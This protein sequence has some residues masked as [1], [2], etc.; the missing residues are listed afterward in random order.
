MYEGVTV[1]KNKNEIVPDDVLSKCLEKNKSFFGLARAAEG[2]LIIVRQKFSPES[3]PLTVE[4]LNKIQN[5]PEYKS[6][7]LV[8]FFGNA[9]LVGEPDMQP[10]VLLEDSDNDPILAMFMDGNFEEFKK[11]GSARPPEVFAFEEYFKPK[12]KKLGLYHDF[13]LNKIMDEIKSSDTSRDYVKTMCGNRG[14][15][16]FLSGNGRV[17]SLSVKGDVSSKKTSWGWISDTYPAAVAETI[18]EKKEEPKNAA[19]SLLAGLSGKPKSGLP[20]FKKKETAESSSVPAPDVKPNGGDQQVSTPVPAATPSDWPTPSDDQIL[21]PV[22]ESLRNLDDAKVKKWMRNRMPG[23]LLPKDWKSY[24]LRGY[25]LLPKSG[26]PKAAREEAEKYAKSLPGAM[27]KLKSSTTPASSATQPAPAAK[28]VPSIPSFKK[29]IASTQPITGKEKEYPVKDIEPTHVGKETAS[30]IGVSS[31]VIPPKQKADIK[32]I[33]TGKEFK[34]TVD[35]HGQLIQDPEQRK[36]YEASVPSFAEQLAPVIS[37]LDDT[38]EWPYET[39]MMMARSCPDAV[40]VLAFNWMARS[41]RQKEQ[42]EKLMADLDTATA[43]TTKPEE[44]KVQEQVAQ[45][46]PKIGGVLPS[47]KKKVA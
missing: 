26:A 29:A 13:D 25:F 36:A 7:Q 20:A 27:A 9:D 41:M 21:V 38:A 5:N 1:V 2:K 18:P 40:A 3:T 32:G 39:M 17:I 37:S 16:S 14:S 4:D 12:L 44:H 15:I 23:S 8:M 45:P 6:E 46:K 22:P 42:I 28:S 11:T 34:D 43:P 19:D 31:P 30:V 35:R 33:V 47:F 10:F 24:V